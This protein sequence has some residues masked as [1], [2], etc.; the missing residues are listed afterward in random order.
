MSGTGPVPP[1]GTVRLPDRAEGAPLGPAWSVTP[2]LVW[3]V[4]AGLAVLVLGVLGGRPD[5]AALGAPCVLGAVWALWARPRGSV[6]ADVVPT[7]EGRSGAELT[8]E[9][10]LTAPVGTEA[11]RVRVSRPGH[12]ATEALVHVPLTRTLGVAAASVRTGPQDLFRV[13]RQGVG[14]G[15]LVVGPVDEEPPS[16]VLVL[17]TA[18]SVADLPLPTRL[19]GL[20]GQHESRRAGDGGGLRDIH[21]FQPGDTLRRIDWRATARRSPRLEQLYVR[22]TLALA[23]A[24]VTLVVD[25]RDEVG[26][27]PRTWSGMRAIRPDDATSLDLARQAAATV[28]QGFLAAGDRVGVEDLGV[29]RRALRPGAGRR[30]LDRVV[31]QLALLRPEGDPARRVRPPHLTTGSLVVLFSTFLDPEAAELARTW[32]RAGHRVVA[33]DVLPRLRVRALDQRE[34]VALRMVQIERSDRL[35]DVVAAGAELVRW[36]DDDASA[37]LQAFARLSHRRPGPGVG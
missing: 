32:R 18:R 28:A 10:R 19:R 12:G 29:R 31:H 21:P 13:E 5:V 4:A 20:S 23:E 16:V 1:R 6:W 3:T 37:R 33:V 7:A 26:P 34:R 30:Q 14:P 35:D 17:P 25:S 22:R 27:D 2:P 24:V 8:A 36:A 15:G 9:V 11:V